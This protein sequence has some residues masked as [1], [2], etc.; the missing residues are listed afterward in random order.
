MY[1]S[2]RNED[3][4][5]SKKIFTLANREPSLKYSEVYFITWIMIF[6]TI[7]HV[8]KKK[9]KTGMIATDPILSKASSY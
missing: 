3:E 1:S 2:S 5:K 8:S 9:M 6:N 7:N 4:K